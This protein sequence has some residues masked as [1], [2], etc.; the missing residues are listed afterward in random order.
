MFK[1]FEEL[2]AN[3]KS[4]NVKKRLA[5]SAAA[6]SH[7]IEAVLEAESGKI[8]TP[9]FVGNEKRIIEILRSMDKEEQDY[10]IID[11]PDD[12]LSCKK[13]VALVKNHEADFLMKGKIDT[14]VL[15][16]AV[17]DKEN[18]L[19]TGSVMS[20]VGL[21]QVPGYHKLMSIVDGGMI[22]YPNLQQKK[23]I[24]E[25]TVSALLEMGYSCPNVGIL[26]C[27]EKVNP[28]MPETVDA[29]VLKEMNQNGEIK[30]CVVEGP[31]SFDC[32]VDKEICKI[33]GYESPVAGEV[34]IF[35]MPNIH[36][37]NI[38]A[39]AMMCTGNAKMAGFVAG[40]ACPIVLS[41]RGA[42]AEEKFYSIAIAAA[43]C[44]K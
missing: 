39:K 44:K 28:K 19:G 20:H 4:A 23:A 8:I 10:Y 30:N 13:A 36:T 35:L 1:S 11:E 7:T 33:K 6:D 12:A 37:A 38:S 14:S 5:V 31:I 40:A 16:K 41:S 25:N 32:A 9:I 43:A 18:G 42:S 24:I 21:F 22:P 17:L 15:M 34:D 27:V 3:L 26:A 29:A 2:A